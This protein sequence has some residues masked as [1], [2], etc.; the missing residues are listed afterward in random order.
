VTVLHGA[1]HGLLQDAQDVTG[2]RGVDPAG[3]RRP[4]DVEVRNRSLQSSAQRRRARASSSLQDGVA[5]ARPQTT[6]RVSSM[7]EVH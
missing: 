1:A 6:V 5:P 3:G 2:Q 4:G 7:A